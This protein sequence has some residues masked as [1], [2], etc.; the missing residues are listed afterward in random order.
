VSLM[1][2]ARC[3]PRTHPATR[4]LPDQDGAAVGS[5]RAWSPHA[6]PADDGIYCRSAAELF[7]TLLPLS[8]AVYANMSMAR[9]FCFYRHVALG[10]ALFRFAQA[11]ACGRC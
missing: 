7:L 3:R 5:S 1:M 9:A 10:S 2:S 4:A 6:P 11:H 8:R